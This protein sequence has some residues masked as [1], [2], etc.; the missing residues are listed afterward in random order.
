LFESD[1]VTSLQFQ[2]T[3]EGKGVRGSTPIECLG[4]GNHYPEIGLLI[5]A[6]MELVR[7]S[8]FS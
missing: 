2:N 8:F 6:E 4:A 5:F 3:Q 1:T 7:R